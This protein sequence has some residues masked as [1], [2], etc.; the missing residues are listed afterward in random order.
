M[1]LYYNSLGL[2]VE[3][4]VRTE[5]GPRVCSFL[6]Y[7]KDNPLKINGLLLHKDASML[8]LAMPPVDVPYYMNKRN[9]IKDLEDLWSTAIEEAQKLLPENSALSCEAAVEYT[10]DELERDP[11]ASILGCSQSKNLYTGFTPIPPSYQNNTRYGGLHINLGRNENRSFRPSDVLMLDATLGLVSVSQHE[12]PF[13][14]Q[15]IER[16]KYYGRAGEYRMKTFPGNKSGLEYRTLPAS[17]WATMGAT[18][19]FSC[20]QTLDARNVQSFFPY[21]KD[22]QNAINTCD[23][24]AATDLLTTM[25]VCPL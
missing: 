12:Q 17:T 6:P 1:S 10:D 21:Y 24:E 16:R 4:T 18:G 7:T 25:K 11:Y 20:L 9:P 23:G 3:T 2:E 14:E 5:G 13:K 19:L 8:E 22:I 15:M